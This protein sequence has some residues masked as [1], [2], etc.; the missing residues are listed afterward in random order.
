MSENAFLVRLNEWLCQY[1]PELATQP[2]TW[3]VD[4]IDS[5]IVDSLLFVEFLM[6][7]EHLAGRELGKIGGSVEP[8]RTPRTIYTNFI[9]MREQPLTADSTDPS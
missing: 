9:A 3:D 6:F 4:L 1:R 2:L 5:R 8:F 7:V